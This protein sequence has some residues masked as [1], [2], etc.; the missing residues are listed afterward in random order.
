MSSAATAAN[1][2]LGVDRGLPFPLADVAEART[3]LLA[4]ANPAEAMPPAM[5]YL[6]A[7]RAAGARH[8]VVDP[9]R[10]HTAAGSYLHLQ[11]LTGT[12]REAEIW[13]RRAPWSPKYAT[14]P[15]AVS[16]NGSVEP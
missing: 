2:S 1:R 14:L 6:D 12:C 13:I 16:A 9:R 15:G 11:P 5:Q 3:V 10:T 7:G 4:G 8:I